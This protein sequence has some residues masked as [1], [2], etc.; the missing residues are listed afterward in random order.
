MLSVRAT[1][2]ATRTIK[3]S[4]IVHQLG[5]PTIM[6]GLDVEGTLHHPKVTLYS[7]DPNLT[8][9]DILSFLIFGH[10]A[11]ANTPTNVNLLVNAVDTL[12]IGG[13]KTSAGG[14]VDQITQGL[15]LTELGIESQTT[16]AALGGP[17]QS[18][19]VV[20]RLSFPTNL[21]PL[22]PGNY[23]LHQCHPNPLFN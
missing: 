20:G 14:V 13:G 21:Y 4:P 23:Y 3:T 18:A 11:N 5:G 10:S 9:A 2:T 22:Q 17:T 8:Q 19:F 15:G 16:I 6:V 1:R 12:N 7:S